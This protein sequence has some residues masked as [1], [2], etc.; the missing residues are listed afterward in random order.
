[1][2]LATPPVVKAALEESP[3]HAIETMTFHT[4]PKTGPLRHV[5]RGF[6]PKRTKPDADNCL[7]ALVDALLKQDSAVVAKRTAKFWADEYGPRTVVRVI[8]WSAI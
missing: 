7:K 4:R 8:W 5:L 3:P 2:R 6:D 1:M